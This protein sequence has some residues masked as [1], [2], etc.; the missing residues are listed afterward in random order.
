MRYSRGT[1][2]YLNRIALSS[3]THITSMTNPLAIGIEILRI[4]SECSLK[5]EF[6]ELIP[7]NP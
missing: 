4:E 3:L 2:N 1:S 7:M 6:T 5:K